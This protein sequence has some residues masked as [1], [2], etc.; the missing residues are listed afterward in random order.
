MGAAGKSDVGQVRT[1]DLSESTICPLARK[2]RIRL[3]RRGI[4][5]G[6]FA[7]WSIEKAQAHR[8]GVAKEIGEE[9][10]PAAPEWGRERHTLA[11][12]MTLPGVFG[13]GLAAMGLDMISKGEEG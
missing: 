12:Q 2:V 8:P 4:A 7:I 1:G 5:T 3:K 11:S 9:T 13:Y 10:D 6:I